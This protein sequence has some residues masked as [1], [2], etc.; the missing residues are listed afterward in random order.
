MK[1]HAHRLHRAAGVLL[2][3]TLLVLPACG[4]APARTVDVPAYTS[5]HEPLFE[6]GIDMV[7][8]P[9]DLGG[10]WLESYDQ[11]LDQ[12]IQM[13][14][15]VALVTVRTLRTDVDLDRRETRRIVTEIDRTFI[16][17]ETLEGEDL[18]LT[19]QEGTG[20]YGSVITNERRLLNA[21]FIAFVKWERVGDTDLVAHWHLSPATDD[22]ALRVRRELERRR[23]VEQDYN[24]R[25]TVVVHRN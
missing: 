16:G 6:N 7:E 17:E 25:R 9:D 18:V 5:A 23:D 24:P 15:V 11:E 8:A 14:D 19:V 22:V 13:A 2:A 20:G 1:S 10:S 12:R 21:R 3:L 4:G